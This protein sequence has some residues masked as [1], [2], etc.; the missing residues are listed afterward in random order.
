MLVTA[1]IVSRFVIIFEELQNSVN[2]RAP[3]PRVYASLLSS[4]RS[5]KQ[6]HLFL[7]IC[8]LWLADYFS[9]KKAAEVGSWKFSLNVFRSV[10]V[11]LFFRIMS[12]DPSYSFNYILNLIVNGTSVVTE[13][14]LHVAVSRDSICF[15][16]D[17]WICHFQKIN[18]FMYIDT[19]S[20]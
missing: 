15:H 19:I 4:L 9:L 1:F 12:T 6:C 20:V 8:I 16:G 14:E 2:E 3:S 5:N 10:F 18:T 13:T 7:Y 11:P 17:I